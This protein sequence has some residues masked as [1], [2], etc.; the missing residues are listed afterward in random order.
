MTGGMLYINGKTGRI[1]NAGSRRCYGRHLCMGEV[2]AACQGF[3][4]VAYDI[5]LD[6]R[7]DKLF[8]G[9]YVTYM[10]PH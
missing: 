3:G 9:K 10:Q 2:Y 8:S 5:Y 1:S 7:G 4:R 6:S